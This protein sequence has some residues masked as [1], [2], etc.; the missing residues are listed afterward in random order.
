MFSLELVLGD[1]TRV[2]RFFLETSVPFVL[3]LFF[4]RNHLSD[5]SF[6][7]R[8]LCSVYYLFDL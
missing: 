2:V 1:E 6:A 7:S 3:S 4:H 8:L 5:T